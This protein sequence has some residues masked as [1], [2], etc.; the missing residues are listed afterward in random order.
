VVAF[1]L[2]AGLLVERVKEVLEVRVNAL[3]PY[4]LLDSELIDRLL[5]KLLD[6]LQHAL[7]RSFKSHLQVIGQLVLQLEDL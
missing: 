5:R 3:L 1:D 2:A 4:Q 7:L 6:F